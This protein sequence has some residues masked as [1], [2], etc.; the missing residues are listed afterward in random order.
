MNKT[1]NNVH[2]KFVFFMHSQ[3]F[4]GILQL[5]NSGQEVEDFVLDRIDN[6]KNVTIAKVLKQKNGYDYYL[7]SQ[8]FLQILGKQLQ[9]KFGGELKVSTK[10]HTRN[11]VTSKEVHRVTVLFRPPKF[12]KGDIVRYRGEDLLIINCG[13]KVYCKNVKSNKKMS[14]PYERFN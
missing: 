10:L 7:S 14:I 6:R 13:T 5:R 12:K 11:R 9:Q 4:E 8:K 3:Y 1:D 2:K